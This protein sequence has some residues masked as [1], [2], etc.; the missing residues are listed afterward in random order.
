MTKPCHKRF[1]VEDI[2]DVAMVIFTDQKIY[3]EQNIKVIGEQ[4]FLLVD[5]LG[6]KKIILNFKNVNYMSSLLFGKLI[7]LNKK[8]VS[9][10]GKLVLCDLDPKSREV[11]EIVKLDKLFVIVEDDQEALKKF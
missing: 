2:G 1:E 8:L 9:I 3:D 6:K 11:F 7:T 10:G 5:E 4:L